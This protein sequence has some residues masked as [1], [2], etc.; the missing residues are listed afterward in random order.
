MR[1]FVSAVSVLLFAA[2]A[3]S[4]RAAAS[5]V[6]V[7]VETPGLSPEEVEKLVT[8]PIESAVFGL[9]RVHS[10]RSASELG[11]SIVWVT[12]ERGGDVLEQRQKV[13]ER[14]QTVR[15]VLSAKAQPTLAP[16][17]ANSNRLLR[18]ALFTE[19]G[20][21][22]DKDPAD[23]VALRS[24]AESTVRLRLL[25]IPGVA[26]VTVAGGQR[27]QYQV[28]ASP[29]RLAA[30]NLT[31][32]Q[33]FDALEK[34]TAGLEPTAFGKSKLTLD[35]LSSAVVAF[36]DGA[37]IRVRDVATV[38][39]GGVTDR[40]DAHVSIKAKE[41]KSGGP[42]VILTVLEQPERNAKL[43]KELR[44]AVD[45]IEAALPPDWRLVLET[46]QDSDVTVHLRTPGADDAA[47][48]RRV[49]QSAEKLLLDVPEVAAVWRATTPREAK[50]PE[51][52]LDGCLLHLR[53]SK[54]ARSR[55]DVVAEIRRRL[56]ELPGVTAALLRPA[57][58]SV[59][60][61]SAHTDGVIK[62]FGDDLAVLRR[63]AEAL[64]GQLQKVPGL[65]DLRIDPPESGTPGLEVKIDR[66]A[67]ARHGI[68]VA[69]IAD[70]LEVVRAGRPCGEL[71][72]NGQ[73]V[74]VV[75][76]YEGAPR[77]PEEVSKL[78]LNTATGKLVP[79]SAL[80]RLTLTEGPRVIYR[81]NLKRRVLV[82]YNI[83]GRP[84]EEI[85][86]ELERIKANFEAPSGYFLEFVPRSDKP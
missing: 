32:G 18:V 57:I 66:E 76:E 11:R 48:V 44:K 72:E 23:A 55:D 61:P 20:K 77:R 53:L 1:G 82:S 60:S 52:L 78:R 58:P 24:V 3:L 68:S 40:G 12:F 49:A 21:A 84:K 62:L 34:E 47:K 79:L 13:A 5:T 9:A 25:R 35:D 67:A 41:D 69:E 16:Q 30:H 42:A 80:A 85:R 59:D 6:T 39:A 63:L 83:H 64:R 14:L 15:D 31:V 43:E 27:K 28:L 36:R 56:A 71:I 29:D 37:P 81:E 54:S 8:F 22:K 19:G 4:P 86:K 38:R 51:L 73:R 10:V 74:E 75:G 7:V 65:A 70:F 50:G 26:D 45:E 17:R 33:L 46:F 2:I